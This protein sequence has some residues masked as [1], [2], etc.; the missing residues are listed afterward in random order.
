METLG[1]TIS[2]AARS[3]NKL[4]DCM[5]PI[6]SIINKAVDTFIDLVVKNFI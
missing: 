2:V 4:G 1:Y 3:C 5:D 6:N